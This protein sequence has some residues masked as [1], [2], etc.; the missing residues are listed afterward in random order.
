MR[1]LALTALIPALLLGREQA[2]ALHIKAARD[3]FEQGK[4][5]QINKEIERAIECY[6]RAIEIEPTFLDARKA[7]I[8]AYLQGGE[9]L[10][11]AE[12]I[13][14][15]LEIQPTA[16][17]YRLRLGRILLEQKQLEKALAQFS[18]VLRSQPYDADA[19]LGFA[20]AASLLGMKDRAIE[21]IERGRTRYPD[22]QRFKDPPL[23][24]RK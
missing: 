3:A 9:E 17:S 22:D 2:P 6:Q 21:A 4:S 20:S 1:V 15:Y 16:A 14:E 11:E 23:T 8:A 5:A 24:L 12:A 13:T 7:L 10:K 19:L 18:A